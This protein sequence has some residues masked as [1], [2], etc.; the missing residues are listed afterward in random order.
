MNMDSQGE[1]ILSAQMY[2]LIGFIAGAIFAGF[3]SYVYGRT[4]G[5]ERAIDRMQR[6]LVLQHHAQWGAEE[7]GAPKFE[8]INACLPGSGGRK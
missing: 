1:F 6:E 2:I 3:L 8:L 5:A 4:T 7:T